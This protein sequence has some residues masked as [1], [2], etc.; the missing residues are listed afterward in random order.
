LKSPVPYAVPSAARAPEGAEI[1]HV[2]AAIEERVR[3]AFR[4]LDR[5]PPIPGCYLSAP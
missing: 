5:L 3:L 4:S 1:H 2:A